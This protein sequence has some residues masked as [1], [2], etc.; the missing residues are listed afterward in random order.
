MKYVYPAIFHPENE[1]GFSIFF[2]D[3]E[4]CYTQGDTMVEA[5]EMAEDALNLML[6]DKEESK[7]PIPSPSIPQDIRLEDPSDCIVWVSADTFKYR[8]MYDTKSVK[9]TLS[10]PRWLDTLAVDNNVNFSNVLQNALKKQL[11]V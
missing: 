9:K 3:I 11:G 1:G 5:V 6:W 8:K 7:E 2:P 4:G 10:I